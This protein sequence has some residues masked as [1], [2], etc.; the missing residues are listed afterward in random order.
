VV[1][2]VSGTPTTDLCQPRDLK[3]PWATS[4][5]DPRNSH[6]SGVLANQLARL[7]SVS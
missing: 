6:L 2:D 5:L 3:V 4:A 7:V 1:M